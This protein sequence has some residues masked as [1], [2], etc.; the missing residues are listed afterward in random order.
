MTYIDYIGINLFVEYI[1]IIVIV[2]SIF[3][4][5]KKIYC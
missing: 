3:L 2:C 4:E 5:T 1:V